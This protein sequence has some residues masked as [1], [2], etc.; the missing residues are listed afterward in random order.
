MLDPIRIVSATPAL[1]RLAIASAIFSAVQ[2]S[3]TAF[4]VTYL[5]ERLTVPIGAAGLLMSLSLAASIAT[6]LIWGWVADWIT[7]IRVIGILSLG[8]AAVCALAP[9]MSPTWPLSVIGAVGISF[10]ATA[11]SWNGIYLAEIASLSSP[12]Q[13]SAITGGAMVFT[14]I[15]AL[16]GPA[17]FSVLLSTTGGYT[18][19][20]LVLSAM[21]LASALT[22]LFNGVRKFQDRA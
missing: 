3:F 13:V 21:A 8:T 7:A 6:R 14:W 2:F 18:T 11:L 1:R 17:M 10:G 15:G 16:T 19:G 5:V 12:E 9:G 4:F 20:F 22:I